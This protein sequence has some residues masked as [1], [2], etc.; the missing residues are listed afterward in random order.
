MVD[1]VCT[2]GATDLNVDELKIDVC[3]SATQKVLGSAAGLAP[4]TFSPRAMEVIINRKVPSNVFY[5]DSKHLSNL[6]K[7][8]DSDRL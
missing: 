5:F 2:L 8:T 7:C 4:I 1:A 6:W 3:F